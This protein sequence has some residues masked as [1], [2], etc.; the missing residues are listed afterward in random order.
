MSMETTPN[1]TAKVR[2]APASDLDYLRSVESTLSEWNSP[3][4]DEAFQH[5][6]E[7]PVPNDPCQWPRSS[8]EFGAP[9]IE[10]T[11]PRHEA[12]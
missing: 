4:D 3:S 2:V 6:G 12:I 9:A 7:P 8:A 1:G 10:A 5:L 11:R